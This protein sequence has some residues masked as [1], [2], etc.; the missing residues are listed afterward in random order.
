MYD[1]CLFKTRGSPAD[2][3][4]TGQDVI[5][6]SELGS[7]DGW[8]FFPSLVLWSEYTG[9]HIVKLRPLAHG[10]YHSTVPC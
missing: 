8:L 3:E 10:E 7:E 6:K 5:F 9:E 2:I 4:G 1:F